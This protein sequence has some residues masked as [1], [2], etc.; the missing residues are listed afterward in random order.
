MFLEIFAHFLKF[1]NVNFLFQIVF[2]L[3]LYFGES[4]LAAALS[5]VLMNWHLQVCL[6]MFGWDTQ[7][8]TKTESYHKII[9]VFLFNHKKTQCIL[10]SLL[11]L[12]FLNSVVYPD[13]MSELSGVAFLR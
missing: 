4:P 9:R 13:E 7:E 2:R 1:K 8:Q 12:G 5:E 6:Q 10:L 11:V 3:I